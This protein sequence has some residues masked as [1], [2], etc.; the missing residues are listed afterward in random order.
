MATEGSVMSEARY[1]PIGSG[2]FTY[3]AFAGHQVEIRTR[4]G[5][6]SFSLDGP[7][8]RIAEL[9]ASHIEDL[10]RERSDW[11]DEEVWTCPGCGNRR[12]SHKIDCPLL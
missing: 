3:I 11:T 1:Y 10:H 9:L 4:D 7:G 2:P 6:V 12:G 5:S 8:Q